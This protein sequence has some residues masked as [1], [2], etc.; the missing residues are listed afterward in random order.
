MLDNFARSRHRRGDKRPA[1]NPTFIRAISRF[2][3]RPEIFTKDKNAT[4]CS[5]FAVIIIWPAVV[6]V[7]RC[8]G[9]G[10]ISA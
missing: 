7:C 2:A 3:F 8:S 5:V 6:L 9:L 4:S 1:G 10:V